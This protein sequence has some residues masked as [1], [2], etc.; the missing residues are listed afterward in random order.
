VVLTYH[1]LAADDVEGFTRQMNHLRRTAIPVFPDEKPPAG[2]KTSTAVT[3]DDGFANVFEYG[4]PILAALKIPAVVFIPTRYIGSRPGW[5]RPGHQC[6]CADQDLVSASTIRSINA[7]LVRV[8]SHGVTH[9]RLSCLD[10]HELK[11]ELAT[12]KNVLEEMTG[13]PVRLLS[14]P[15]GSGT[16]VVHEA[17]KRMGYERVFSN[18]P[19][20]TNRSTEG[21]LA[22]RVDVSPH[23]SLVEFHLKAVGAY[24]WMA[25]AVPAKQYVSKWLARVLSS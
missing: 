21:V 9:R 3:F 24:Q 23:D 1:N 12:S 18:V 17:A 19:L 4:M 22:G 2:G 10:L 5:L 13:R 11:A 16:P 14:L 7:Q 6:P 20:W 15:Y 25:V 8:G